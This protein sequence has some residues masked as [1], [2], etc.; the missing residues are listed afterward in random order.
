[1]PGIV[2]ASRIRLLLNAQKWNAGQLTDQITLAAPV[3][4]SGA[5]LQ[6]ELFLTLD[7]TTVFDFTNVGSVTIE[8]STSTSPINNNIV[9]SQAINIANITTNATLANFQ[10]GTSAATG[11]QITALIPNALTQLG[12]NNQGTNYKLVVYATST[13][14]TPRNQPLL[15]TSISTVDAGLPQTNPTLPATFKAGS[16][17][18]F[19]CSDGKT[20]NVTFNLMPNG[21]WALDIEQAGHNGPGQAIYSLFCS[22]A[23]YR[24]LQVLLVQGVW[25]LD[26]GQNGHS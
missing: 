3:I 7:G 21:H 1:M 20:R 14:A 11:Q 5:D 23:Q 24:D 13:D 4:P 16:Y 22:D 26:I 17:L 2:I 18:P 8:L 10:N 15:V 25:T 9:W 19:V 6:L 12:L